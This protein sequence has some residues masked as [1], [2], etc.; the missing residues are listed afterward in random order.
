[1]FLRG[2]ISISTMVEGHDALLS[3]IEDYDQTTLELLNN[4]LKL[5]QYDESLGSMTHVWSEL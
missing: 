3:L 2:L 5:K 1:M 4:F